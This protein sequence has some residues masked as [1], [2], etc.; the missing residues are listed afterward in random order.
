[1]ELGSNFELD[2][3]ELKYEQDNIFEY[4]KEYQTIYTDSGRSALKILN[5]VLEE[6]MILLPAYICESVINIYKQNGSIRFYRINPDMTIDFDDLQQKMDSQVKMVYLM[7]YFGS[8]QNNTVL[9]YLKEKKKEYGYII[10]EDTTH[11]ILTQKRTVGDYCVCSLRKWFPIPDGGVVYSHNPIVEQNCEIQFKKSI[12]YDKLEAMIL[13]K[14]YIQYGIDCNLIYRNLFAQSEERLDMQT[15]IY[16]MSDM[17]RDI[18]QCISIADVQKKR[19]RNYCE[20]KKFLENVPVTDVLL[21]DDFVPMVYPVYVHNRDRFRQYLMENKIYCAV[22]WPLVG[23]ELEKRQDSVRIYENIIS[24]PID[25]R[26]G[27]AHMKYL[28]KVLD[29]YF[30]EEKQNGNN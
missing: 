9:N 24:L 8:V 4:L 6:G 17:A 12:V 15:E 27:T 11:S 7:H 13:K 20:L 22:H 5:S 29:T 19:K 21:T 25:Q 18:L 1:M 30:K 28:E 16:Q 10:I 3:S 26:Y 2:L 14:Y 23:T